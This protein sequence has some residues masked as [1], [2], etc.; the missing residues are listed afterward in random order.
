MHQIMIL[1]ECVTIVGEWERSCACVVCRFVYV[2]HVHRD[3][4][5]W[6]RS[7]GLTYIYIYIYIYGKTFLTRVARSHSPIMYGVCICTMYSEVCSEWV[8]KILVRLES[9]MFVFTSTLSHTERKITA[10]LVAGPWSSRLLLVL[11]M[12]MYCSVGFYVSEGE[13]CVCKQQP[14][15]C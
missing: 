1:E 3:S 8:S 4:I 10:C 2:E 5:F 12:E 9:Q 6:H 15:E 14:P 7:V 13:L 11:P